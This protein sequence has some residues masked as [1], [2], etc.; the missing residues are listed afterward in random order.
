MSKYSISITEAGE[1]GSIQNRIHNIEGATE[2]TDQAVTKLCE[3]V[4]DI[5]CTAQ[6]LAAQHQ[7]EFEDSRELFNT[8]YSWA[9]E[10][11]STHQ[12]E[13]GDDQHGDY[14]DAIDEFAEKMLLQTY[15]VEEQK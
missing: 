3:C 12:H 11:E 5:S 4:Y 2:M 7:I 8:I 14:I 15:G 9:K 13:W 6:H 1:A 10:F